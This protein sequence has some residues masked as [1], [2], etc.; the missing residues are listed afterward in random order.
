[1]KDGPVARVVGYNQIEVSPNPGAVSE[2]YVNTEAVT[3]NVRVKT[4]RLPQM[5]YPAA[6]LYGDISP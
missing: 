1:M 2:V 3:E 6:F 4:A 5:N